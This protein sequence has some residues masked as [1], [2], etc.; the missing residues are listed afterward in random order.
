MKELGT[1]IPR[2]VKRV[3]FVI[4]TLDVGGTETQLALL[5]EGLIF[6]GWIVEIFVLN[7]CGGLR[8][9]LERAGI[10][11]VDGGYRARSKWRLIW[12]MTLA[13]S[14]L[15]LA[16]H[17]LR[18]RPLVVHGFLPLTNFYA[19][20]AGRLTRRPLV[21]SSKRALG[22]HQERHP[23][24]K[25]LDF[26]SN[27]L[28]HIVTANSRAVAI[29]TARRDNYP[30]ADIKVIYNG[31]DFGRFEYPSNLR[32]S[33]REELGLN[34]D[35]VAIVIVA[36][37]IPYKGHAELIEAFGIVLDAHSKCR[38]FIIGEDRGV[39]DGLVAAI[40]EAPWRQKVCFLEQR[41]DVPELLSAMDIGVLASH[42]EGLS[43]A[44]LE[45]LA[46][47]LPVLVTDVGGNPEAIEDMPG[48]LLCRPRDP[49]DLARGLIK[50]ISGLPADGANRELRRLRIRKKFSVDTMIDSYEQMYLARFVN[51]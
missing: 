18:A 10:R 30:L 3:T 26:I 25:W 7:L 33:R 51:G 27:R 35:E 32:I 9:R 48:C 46:A 42:E 14:G 50:I 43:N 15:K 22:T 21:V 8:P 29:D 37:I 2:G 34:A 19:A 36:N 49:A 45:K 38:L 6:R 41:R 1:G 47:G 12:M 17:L 39:R 20:L 4:G 13:K 16:W 23:K 24:L 5:S 44:L 40:E 11:M 28:S 31:L